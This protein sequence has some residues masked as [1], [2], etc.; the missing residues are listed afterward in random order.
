M[1]IELIDALDKNGNPTGERKTRL[2]ILDEGDWRNVI[3]VWLVNDQQEL[4]VQQRASRG[5]WDNLWDISVGGGVSSGEKPLQ[6]AVRELN[7][8]LGIRIKPADLHPLGVWD[9]SKSLP[10]RK[11]MAHEFS[12]SYL[13][14]RDV[15]ISSLVLQPEEVTQVE[16]LGLADLKRQMRDNSDYN[17]WVP[18]PK[19]YYLEVINLIERRIK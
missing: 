17:N 13:L 7:E 18:H 15:P 19:K 10:E 1:N 11:V 2:Q 12:Y 8:E 16:Y 3:H 5:L 9:T 4:L 6:T 14:H